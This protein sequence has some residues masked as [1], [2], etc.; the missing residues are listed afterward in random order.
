MGSR[1]ALAGVDPEARTPLTLVPRLDGV[2]PRP[3]PL[4]PELALVDPVLAEIARSFLPEPGDCLTPRPRPAG[5][6]PELVALEGAVEG[7]VER[8]AYAVVAAPSGAD[9]SWLDRLRERQLASAELERRPRGTSRLRAF[10]SGAGFAVLGAA[11]LLAGSQAWHVLRPSSPQSAALLEAAPHATLPTTAHVKAARASHKAATPVIQPTKKPAAPRSR[12]RSP[13]AP[14]QRVRKA[15]T[16][17]PKAHP[18]V[19]MFVWPAVKSARFYRLEMFRGGTKVLQ[20]T[21][22]QPRFALHRSWRYRG[23]TVA[24]TSGVYVWI[25]RP[26]T[27]RPPAVRYGPP[28]TRSRWTVGANT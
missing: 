6:D 10:S 25:V 14:H 2:T 11:G 22:R 3:E 16:R 12:T 7:A 17:T 5:P 23:R 26:A 13:Q 19:H 20:A 15:A 9:Q 24:L 21:P 18:R 8:A 1:M 27:G 28:V 4:S